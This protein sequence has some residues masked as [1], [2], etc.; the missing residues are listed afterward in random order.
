MGSM[1]KILAF[2]LSTLC[3]LAAESVWAE[4]NDVNINGFV[5]QGFLKSDNN[6]YLCK[7]ED[8]SFE[9]N[10][11]GINFT[12]QLSS[13]LR[14]GCQFF[15]RDLGDVGNDDV[16][17]DW[18]FADYRF[19][20]MVGLRVGKLKL[21]HGLYNETRDV[22]A[23]RT[24]ILL[25]RGIYMEDMREVFMTIKGFGVYGE[26][27]GEI[28]YQMGYGIPE[29]SEDSYMAQRILE[30]VQLSFQRENVDFINTDIGTVLET[31]A[32]YMSNAGLQW[33]SPLEGLRFATS[34]ISFD[35][36]ILLG[37]GFEIPLD[38]KVKQGAVFSGEYTF[39][40]TIV[41]VEYS[42]LD[43]KYGTL[44]FCVDEKWISY[45]VGLSHRFSKLFELGAYY[46]E[47]Y[48]D[49]SDKNGDRFAVIGLPRHMAWEKD[50]CLS[51]RYD[52]N[53]HWIV[54]LEGHIID[55]SGIADQSEHPED[56]VRHF[57]L[58]AA[59]AS[60]RF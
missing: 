26:L 11:I 38:F 25:P 4:M 48:P 10:E 44:G 46:A 39:G 30:F 8:G 6:N 35:I 36:D 49:H 24:S 27:P 52:I 57:S 56:L 59:K 2:I 32:N 37:F 20:N 58:F 12:T 16:L 40:D 22:D 14:M 1:K 29:I 5:S 18:A 31:Q 42:V 34:F 41:T 23:L 51:F 53:S 17:L 55:G 50:S 60:F 19:H 9:F 33:D 13:S 54:K 3:L 15:A 28:S 7:S 45:Y 43:Y 21:T 47:T